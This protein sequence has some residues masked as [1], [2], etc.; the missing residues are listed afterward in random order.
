ML[1][2]SMGNPFTEALLWLH[3]SH[4]QHS[5]VLDALKEEKSVALG[6]CF[7]LFELLGCVV[8]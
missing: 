4:G 3:R 7:V 5:R 1:L 2:A 8:V 6:E